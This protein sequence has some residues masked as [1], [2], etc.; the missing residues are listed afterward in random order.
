MARLQPFQRFLA[1]T[2]KIISI[3]T[4][5]IQVPLKSKLAIRSG[6][7]GS[8]VV[9][10]FLLVKVHTDEGITGLGEVSCTPRWSGEDQ[11]T[12]AH[13]IHNY[14]APALQ[15]KDPAE[16][17]KLTAEFRLAMAG[18]YFTKAG[19][20]MALWD[21]L[22]K[23]RGMPVYKLLGGAVREFIPTKWSISGLKPEQSAEIAKV[24]LRFGR[25]W[26]KNHPFCQY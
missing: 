15:G 4:I 11:V 18:N 16:I 10:P 20:E 26:S 7:G 23:S 12:A 19:V 22:G 17:E 25:R 2:M 6:R 24:P 8:H 3:E 13:F 9:S 21:I 5:P 1:G 14:L